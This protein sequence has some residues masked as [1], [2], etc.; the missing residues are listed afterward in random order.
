M[1]FRCIIVLGVATLLCGCSDPGARAKSTAAPDPTDIELSPELLNTGQ[2]RV[3]TVTATVEPVMIRTSGKIGFDEEHLSHVSSPLVGRVISIQVQ[4]GERVQVGQTLAVIDSPDLGSASSEFIKARADLLLA[5]RTHT[6][7]E[8]LLAAKAMAR[9]DVQKAEDEFVK[10][11]TDLRRT[12]ERLLSLGVPAAELDQPLDALHVRSQFDLTAPISGTV[13]ERTLTLGQ[14]VGGDSAARLFVIADLGTVWITADIYERDLPLIQHG[15]EVRV[16]AVARP[17][18]EFRGR[19]NYIGDTVDPN[20]RTVKVWATVDNQLQRLKPEMFVT[21]TVQTTATKSI[22]TVPL[23]AVHGEGTGQAYVFA[24]EGTRLVRRPVTL[25]TKS[26]HRV[27]VTDGLTVDD[28]IVT[29]GSILF[30]A[31]TERASNS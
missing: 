29:E 25:G 5:E 10:A 1:I 11:K 3:E 22:A 21:V 13:I 26:D 7:A 23:A 27:A 12:R 31:Q 24:V 6:L 2:V 14:M 19:I 9:K 28:R 4:P 20:S 15:E 8:Q 18:E 30:K 17:E 16:H